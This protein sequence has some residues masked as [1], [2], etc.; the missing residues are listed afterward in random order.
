M[1]SKVIEWREIQRYRL[2]KCGA[3]HMNEMGACTGPS[4]P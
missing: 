3:G 4:V 2:I 1:V